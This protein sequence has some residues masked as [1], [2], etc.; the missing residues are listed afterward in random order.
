MQTRDAA[1]A[2]P[3]VCFLYIAQAHHVPHSL[4]VAMELARAR[5]DIAVDVAVTSAE[6]L[7][8]AREAAG[9]LGA[10]ELGWR[11]LGPAWLRALHGSDGVPMKVPMLAANAP[12]LA[13]YDVIVA[14]ERTTALLRRLGL[15]ARLV[16]TQHGAGDRAGPFEPRLRRFDLVFAAGPKQR[17]RMVA[18]GLV[19]PQR[20]AVVG[21]PKFDFIDRLQPAPPRLFARARPTVL[22]NPHFSATLGSW[23]AWGRGILE[24]FASQDRYNLIFAPH[25]RLFGSRPARDVQAL[26]AYVGHPGIHID[27]GDTPAAID[28]TYVQAADLYLGDVSSQI[29]EFLR[30][31]RPCLFLNPRQTPWRDDE[32]FRHWRFG[33]VVD[34]LDALFLALDDAA[35]SHPA[36]RPAQEEG[37]AQTFSVTDERPSRRAAQAI[38]GLVGR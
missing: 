5:P 23:P 22:Y 20:C 27:L 11:L 12:T 10:A 37:F 32:S 14:P 29:Y 25:L 34:R 15:R 2:R 8:Y 19:E 3:R 26:A 17:D 21:Y 28:M 24:R 30:Q 18:E 38:A 7:A 13:G 6:V 36:F 9:R 31:P 16:Y 4:S 1:T 35:A 33:P